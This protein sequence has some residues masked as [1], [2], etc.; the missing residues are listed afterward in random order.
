METSALKC[1]MYAAN[2]TTVECF[3]GCETE[4]EAVA[5]PLDGN[6][7]CG[8]CAAGPGILEA[9]RILMIMHMQSK[10]HIACQVPLPLQAVSRLADQR[11]QCDLP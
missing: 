4:R 11:L 9:A 5:H 7:S 6:V 2:M 10:S 1:E 3:A 8:G